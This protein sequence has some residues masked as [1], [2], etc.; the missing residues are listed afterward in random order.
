MEIVGQRKTILPVLLSAVI[1][2]A[3][4]SIQI[5]EL[6]KRTSPLLGLISGTIDRNNQFGMLDEIISGVDKSSLKEGLIE[7]LSTKDLLSGS[8]GLIMNY[9]DRLDET[10]AEQGVVPALSMFIHDNSGDPLNSGLINSILLSEGDLE[11][12]QLILDKYYNDKK[13]Y[14]NK[15]YL[16][17]FSNLAVTDP[18]SILIDYYDESDL[19]SI[20]KELILSDE[21]IVSRI[22]VVA[23]SFMDLNHIENNLPEYEPIKNFFKNIMIE[24][25]TYNGLGENGVGL[26][27]GQDMFLKDVI[28]TLNTGEFMIPDDSRLTNVDFKLYLISQIDSK[29][30]RYQAFDSMSESLAKLYTIENFLP[31]ISNT[32]LEILDGLDLKGT[33]NNYPETINTL[34][35]ILTD[36]IF[37]YDSASYTPSEKETVRAKYQEDARSA[38]EDMKLMH[39]VYMLNPEIGTAILSDMPFFYRGT[40]DTIR[41]KTNLAE[42]VDQL[43]QDVNSLELLLDSYSNGTRGYDREYL[44]SR[45]FNFDANGINIPIDEVDGILSQLDREKL[46]LMLQDENDMR[47]IFQTIGAVFDYLPEGR[48]MYIFLFN[49]LSIEEYI[50]FNFKFDIDDLDLINQIISE[51]FNN[52]HLA[53]FLF[54]KYDTYID[55]TDEELQHESEFMAPYFEQLSN[56]IDDKTII[57]RL[58]AKLSIDYRVD[59]S[60][61]FL[62]SQNSSFK[63]DLDLLYSSIVDIIEAKGLTD[64]YYMRVFEDSITELS[65]K[66]LEIDNLTAIIES[67]SNVMKYVEFERTYPEFSAYIRNLSSQTG[68]INHKALLRVIFDVDDS[69]SNSR[70]VTIVSTVANMNLDKFKYLNPYSASI[71]INILTKALATIPDS[72]EVLNNSGFE[73]L[74]LNNDTFFVQ[75]FDLASTNITSGN[76]LEPGVIRVPFIFNGYKDNY[77]AK[78]GNQ[79]FISPIIGMFSLELIGEGIDNNHWLVTKDGKSSIVRP[80][81][82]LSQ[83]NPNDDLVDVV[84]TFDSILTLSPVIKY[85]PTHMEV[86]NNAT[87]D[88]FSSF[89]RFYIVQFITNDELSNTEPMSVSP[90]N[91]VV[92]NALMWVRGFANIR[93]EQIREMIAKFGYDPTTIT[94]LISTSDAD[95]TGQI[96]D[97]VRGD[98]NLSGDPQYQ[99]IYVTRSEKPVAYLGNGLYAGLDIQLGN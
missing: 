33:M 50:S 21:R 39:E 19:G 95:V 52:N 89:D 9:F 80:R 20:T 47:F 81:D 74:N 27:S 40:V 82:I 28:K 11:N 67:Y 23:E 51:G 97:P 17:N 72:I 3:G 45:L 46:G 84:E 13:D 62:P 15:L 77:V 26:I 18:N 22:D 12:Q 2:L 10:I 86:V 8:K 44:I 76:Q 34:E 94:V 36:I 16:Q 25:Y 1:T 6:T 99:D 92:G 83:F 75:G 88:F 43:D 37:E 14:E 73:R 41:S 59:N 35:Y 61:R 96:N 60:E 38:I 7:S 69:S 55:F 70:A 49:N 78:F 64:V 79:V 66:D 71:Y 85:T 93:E 87:T 53:A 42:W 63:A 91:V 58:L 68:W 29:E 32:S 4:I 98:V 24:Y 30:G 56:Y 90:G 48:D 65:D 57:S 31:S 5:N 54:L